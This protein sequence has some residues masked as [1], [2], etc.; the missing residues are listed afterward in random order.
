[1]I[2][3]LPTRIVLFGV[4]NSGKSTLGKLFEQHFGFINIAF[5][6]P[7]KRIVKDVFGFSDEDLYGPSDKRSTPYPEFA[8][9]GVCPSCLVPCVRHALGE[10]GPTHWWCGHCDTFYH[11]YI[12]P[13]L[14][15]QTLGTE[16]GRG[17]CE[18]IWARS[19]FRRMDETKSYVVTDGRFMTELSTSREH[20]AFTVLLER[21]LENST[22]HHPSEAAVRELAKDPS[23]FS[24]VLNNKQ[25]EAI[26]NFWK[27]IEACSSFLGENTSRRYHEVRNQTKGG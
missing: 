5:A 12:T 2:C 27:L 16:W 15:C 13:R 3:R 24:Y 18:S 11:K 25:D 22:A 6:D 23:W 21:G 9:S 19:C 4:S 14:A 8:F 7:I 17:L 26:D 1:M 20:R 10:N